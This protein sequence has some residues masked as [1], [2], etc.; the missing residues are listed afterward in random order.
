MTNINRIDNPR[1]NNNVLMYRAG[2]RYYDRSQSIELSTEFCLAIH[3]QLIDFIAELESPE[4][5]RI[6][7]RPEHP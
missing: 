1:S 6:L 2:N 3:F 5:P 4:H 7:E